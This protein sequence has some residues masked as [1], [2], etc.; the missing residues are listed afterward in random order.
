MLNI[1]IRRK[2][3]QA[4]N[5]KTQTGSRMSYQLAPNWLGNGKHDYDIEK[6]NRLAM[7]ITK[8]VKIEKHFIVVGA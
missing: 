6:P 5:Y 2:A 7:W 4:N 3:I 8:I 1:A